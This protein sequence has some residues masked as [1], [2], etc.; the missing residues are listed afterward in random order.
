[1]CK[2]SYS[3]QLFKAVR[4]SVVHVHALIAIQKV[5]LAIAHN[6]NKSPNSYYAH[7]LGLAMFSV[8]Q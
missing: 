1:M 2:V 4:S 7:G 5:N 8:A 6:K 3:I